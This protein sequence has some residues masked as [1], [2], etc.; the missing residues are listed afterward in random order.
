VSGA[1][2]VLCGAGFETPAEVLFLGKKLMVVPMKNQFEQACNAAALSNMGVPVIKNLKEKHHKTIKAWLEC[3]IK[4]SV[5]YPNI[6]Q[7]IID[8]VFS[9]I[10]RG[11]VIQPGKKAYTVKKFR[12]LSLKKILIDL[13]G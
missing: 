3:G 1:E 12:E 6:T 9:S 4:I 10:K 8:L 5:N 13:A 11:T 7:E 2:G